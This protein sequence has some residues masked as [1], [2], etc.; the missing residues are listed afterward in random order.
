MPI[1]LAKL[2][3]DEDIGD[4]LGH[5]CDIEIQDDPKEPLWF[6]VDGSRDFTVLAR[7][8]GGGV[9]IT[10]A[11]SPRIIHASSEG[12]AGVMGGNVDEFLA[13]VV[14]CPYW[15]DLLKFSDGG[16]LDEMRRALPVLEAYWLDEDDDNEAMREHL[17]AAIG[18]TPLDD[19][20][21]VL[22]RNIMTSV[23]FAHTADGSM[24]QPLFGSFTIVRNPMLKPYLD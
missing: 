1:D 3:L 6:T 17:A 7:D 19:V 24:L 8:G 4:A 15:H 2:L 20:A 12:Q 18:I 10:V 21:G 11:D 13:L 9:Y 5:L 16:K 14:S 22:H 23:K